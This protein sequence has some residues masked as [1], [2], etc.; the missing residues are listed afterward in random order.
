MSL[1]GIFLIREPVLRGL[2]YAAGSLF[3]AIAVAILTF[4]VWQPDE[5]RL[6]LFIPFLS[7]VII[8]AV[9]ASLRGK[10]LRVALVL[11]IAVPAVVLLGLRIGFMW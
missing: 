10:A 6:I 7:G 5:S 11:L 1:G 3:M 2:L 9:A 8:V 4:H